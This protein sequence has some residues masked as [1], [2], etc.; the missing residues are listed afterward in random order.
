MIEVRFQ[1]RKMGALN[2]SAPKHERCFRV[3]ECDAADNS[4]RF[5]ERTF[6]LTTR[7]DIV[8]EA[9]LLRGGVDLDFWIINELG[10]D[11]KDCSVVRDHANMGYRVTRPAIIASDIDEY[12]FL[13]DRPEF[14]P[15]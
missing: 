7:T 10:L 1:R 15:C 3:T 4:A 8:D 11:P 2:I 13:F 9:D 14:I 12:E 5:S 6:S